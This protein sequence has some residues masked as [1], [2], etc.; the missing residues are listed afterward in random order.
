VH[1][2]TD[3]ASADVVRSDDPTQSAAAAVKKRPSWA[4]TE[5]T[6]LPL[7]VTWIEQDRAFNFAVHSEHAESVTLLL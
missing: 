6:P 1:N 7:G 4:Q 2:S 3:V 5:G